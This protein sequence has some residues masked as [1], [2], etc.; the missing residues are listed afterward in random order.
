MRNGLSAGPLAA[1]LLYGPQIQ[2]AC[3]IPPTFSPEVAYAI[4]LNETIEGQENGSWDAAT[5]VSADGGHGLFQLTSSY[6]DDWAD[7]LAN[8]TYAV[9]HFLLPAETFWSNMGIQGDDLV[10]CIAADFNAGRQGALDGHAK[11]DVDLYTTDHYAA[12]ALANYLGL[13]TR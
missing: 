3:E 9:E 10:R 2:A 12:R 11:G 13:Q 6:P 1:G 4:A 5:V 7:P 8:A